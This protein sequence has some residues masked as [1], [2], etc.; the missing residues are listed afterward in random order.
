MLGKNL[1]FVAT[2][3]LIFSLFMPFSVLAN[4]DSGNGIDISSGL[5]GYWNFE[6]NNG[7]TAYDR[8][9]NGNDGTIY[10][11][12]WTT[13]ISG[14][15]LSFDGVDD[16]VDIGNNV[17]PPFP[18]TVSA[19]V[20]LNELNLVSILRNDKWDSGNYRY[21]LAIGCSP[22]GEIFGYYFEGFSA[23]WN[24]IERFSN[25]SVNP[26]GDWHH[27]VVVFHEHN[28]IQLFWDSV[29]YDGYNREG[30]GSGMTYSNA[31]G[32]IGTYTHNDGPHYLNGE[33]DEIR[34]YNRAL[35]NE[36]IEFLYKN[37][38]GAQS[39]PVA[40]V[41]VIVSAAAGSTVLIF[42][43]AT[44]LGKYKFLSLLS[45]IGPLYFRTVD[46]GEVLENNEKRQ[47]MY[48]YIIENQPVVYSDIKKT[49]GLSDGEI[50]WH[51]RMMTQL[52]IIKMKRAGFHLFFY[53]NGP[54]LPQ[55]EFIR[56]TDIQKSIFDLVSKN[57]GI[58]QLELSKE[59]GI[60]QQN[61]SYNL[62][63]LENNG[64]IR[65][66]KIVRIKHYYPVKRDASSI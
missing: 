41:A 38:S 66:E 39:L 33:I 60:A 42:V 12:N 21:G 40:E 55:E 53:A 51:A 58:T 11:A 27:L 24:R 34:V 63:K 2:I 54:K 3:F 52:D 25:N 62:K 19:W 10:G 43:G 32:A 23:P 64:K 46:R 18:V 17:K 22:D 20:K 37:P 4:L 15:A 36:E 5:I 29:K 57:E 30:T 26:V 65:I 35:S 8:S 7:D 56:L 50:N 45:F 61:I 13:G 44:G 1:F 16:Y 6:E 47:C 14:N 49:C 9:G 59:L 31:N 48:N 28:N